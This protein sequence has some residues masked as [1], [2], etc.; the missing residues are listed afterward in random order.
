LCKLPVVGEQNQAGAGGVQTTHGKQSGL[1][2]D[3]IDDARSAFRIAVGAENSGRFV[4]CVIDRAMPLEWF[5]VD[6]DLCFIGIDFDP[7]LR[8]DF[9]IDFNSSLSDQFIDLATRTE[10]CG[11]KQFIDPLLAAKKR[12]GSVGSS[13]WF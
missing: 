12:R 8:D 1:S 3:Q 13:L 9:A 10:P 11:S 6:Q 2:R 4:H 5:A 7:H